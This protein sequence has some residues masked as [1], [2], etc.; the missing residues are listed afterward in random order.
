MI[1]RL[2]TQVSGRDG[3][4]NGVDSSGYGVVV[5]ADGVAGVLFVMTQYWHGL[6]GDNRE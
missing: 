3:V 4:A 5:L 1:E 6:C 2:E